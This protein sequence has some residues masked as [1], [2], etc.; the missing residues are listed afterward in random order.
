MDDYSQPRNRPTAFGPNLRSQTFA[1]RAASWSDT[2]FPDFRSP[3]PNWNDWPKAAIN[4]LLSRS[5]AVAQYQ[6]FVHRAAF[7]AVGGA[8]YH[9]QHVKVS[10]S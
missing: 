3:S 8:S 4:P 1:A 7:A 5:V 10:L 9:A 6:P 2:D